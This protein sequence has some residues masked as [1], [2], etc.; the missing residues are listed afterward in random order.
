MIEC[1]NELY[2]IEDESN[3]DISIIIPCKNEVNNIKWTI[4]SLLES[5]NHLK[6][7]IIVVDDA[8]TDGSTEFLKSYI[9][10]EKYRDIVLIM[11]NNIGAAAA[12]N[13][14]AKVAKGKYLFFFD[15]H[16]KVPDIWADNLI[17]TLEKAKASLVAPCIADITDISLAGYGQ[18]WNDEFK[19]T[20]FSKKPKDGDEIPLAGGAALGITREA[21]DKIGGFDHLFQVWGRE[22]EE[23]CLKAWLYGYRMVINPDVIVQ[24]LFRKSHPYKVTVAN[25]TYNTICLA[26]SHFKM[27]RL[28]KVMDVARRDYYFFN[29]AGEID[30]NSGLIVSQRNKYAIERVYDDEYF[31]EKFNILF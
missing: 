26:C 16:V 15:A 10:E 25:V 5:K 19:I 31:F 18:T 2:E 9:S 3:V 28:K 30:R 13:M 20:W 11:T 7:E 1:I 14:G 6:C 24:H 4:D 21:F 17:D 22:D 8:S 27:E 12:R 23:I 29:A